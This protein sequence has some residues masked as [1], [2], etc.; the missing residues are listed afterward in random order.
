VRGRS[1]GLALTALLATAATAAATP[2]AHNDQERQL[3]GGRVIPEPMQ[4]ANYL[5]FGANGA[6]AE[7]KDAFTELQRLYPRY[8]SI[9]TVADQLHDPNA[10]STGPD[11]IPA[12]M[13]GDTG[14][15]HPLYVIVLTDRSVPDAGKQYVSLMFA[16]SAETCG[17]EGELRSLEDLAKGASENSSTKYDDGKG[18]TGVTHAYTASELLRKTKIFVSVTSPDGWAKGDNDAGYDQNNGAGLNSNRVAPQDGWS[19]SGDVLYR[20]GY[21]T[22]TQSEGLAF[23]RYLRHVRDSE[24]GGKPFSEGADMH[25]PLPFGYILLHDQGNDAAKIERNYDT[26]VRVKAAMDAVHARYASGGGSDT[27]AQAASGAESVQKVLAPFK[28]DGVKGALDPTHLPLQWATHGQIWDM[29]GYTAGSSWGGWMNSRAGLDADAISYE[30]NCVLYA[31]YDPAQMQLFVDNV[32]AILSTTIVRAAARGDG[33]PIRKTDLQGPAGFYDDG[34]R[35]RSNDGNPSPPPAGFPNRP[36]LKQVA[37]LPYDVSQTD[38]FREAGRGVTT[39]PLRDVRPH[40]LASELPS[41]ATLAIADQQGPDPSA[42]KSW[43]A[44]GGNLVLTDRALQLL[45]ALGVGKAGDVTQG[46]GY[47]GYADLDLADPLTKGL[48]KYARQTYDPIGLGYPTLMERDYYYGC[49]N[50]DSECQGQKDSGTQNSAPIWTIDRAAVAKLPG[51]RIAGTV[52]PPASRKSQTEGTKTNRAE[53]GVVPMGKGRIVFFG[54]LLPRPTEAYP[55]WFGLD[56]ET[57][58]Q[59]GQSMLLRALTWSSPGVVA[60]GSRTCRSRRAL[61]LHLPGVRRG[62]RVRSVRVSVNGRSVRG[63]RRGRSGVR[64]DLSKRL[65]GRYTVV[66][67]A[68]TRRGRVTRTVRR[69]R[70]CTPKANRARSAVAKHP[71]LGTVF[72]PSSGAKYDPFS[73]VALG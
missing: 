4:A 36:L 35:I 56:P 38:W 70:T 8:L 52:D 47:V 5:Q 43:V 26:A 25:G 11:G 64:I 31:P 15:G 41:L 46:Y 57:I 40:R 65:A 14:D 61:T 1:L 44:N 17:R 37:Q 34:T 45:P 48:T 72:R 22:A 62:D 58:S 33:D 51:A 3:Y 42:L 9:T 12:G 63:V 32:R 10:L 18:V 21:S 69:Y 7:L 73:G 19:Y 2:I 30:I 16:H 71:A 59:A 68:R 50:T 27:Y 67:R 29:L 39:A 54:A 49:K 24:L 6:E 66:V 13:P 60:A 55:H 20:H 23:T 53:I 28:P